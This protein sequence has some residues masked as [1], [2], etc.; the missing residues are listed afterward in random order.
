MNTIIVNSIVI[1][2][3]III[4]VILY[5]NHKPYLSH[6]KMSATYMST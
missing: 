3:I 1:S 2:T 6:W 5:I 4:I